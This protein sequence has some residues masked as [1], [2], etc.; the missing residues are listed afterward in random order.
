MVLLSAMH[1]IDISYFTDPNTGF[2]T[3]GTVWGRYLVLIVPVAMGLAGMRTVGPRAV[4]VLRLRSPGLAVLFVLATVVG[5]AYGGTLIYYGV[6][7]E[8]WFD[9][10]M[11]ALFLWYGG[12]MFCG[13]LQLFV[14][15]AP[16]PT[17]SAVWGIFAALPYCLLTIQRVLIKPT[18]LHRVAPFVRVMAALCAMLWFGMLL[19]AFYIALTRR[20]VRWMYLFGILTFLF[21]TCLDFPQTLHAM[22]R[23]TS[24][25]LEM[26]SAVNTGVFGLVAGCVSVAIAGRSA[27]EIVKDVYHRQTSFTG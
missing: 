15:Y 24:T 21:C 18:S 6:R 5:I 2:V 22:M 9:T 19:R 23:G 11:G 12:W 4:G 16:S 7:T 13:A 25:P 14:Q 20:R 1:W 27:P 3:L 10:V 8:E 26:M 17:R